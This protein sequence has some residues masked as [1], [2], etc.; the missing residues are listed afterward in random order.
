MLKLGTK[1]RIRHSP[2]SYVFIF[3]NL[4]F[5]TW[6]NDVTNLAPNFG[7]AN[8]GHLMLL[9]ER[10]FHKDLKTVEMLGKKLFQIVTLGYAL[11][12]LH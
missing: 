6:Q 1:K 8:M 5:F 10:N 7:F 9:F 4:G 2:K 11:G 12:T 3:K